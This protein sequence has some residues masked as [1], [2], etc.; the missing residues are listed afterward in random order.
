MY[1]IA[2]FI[3]MNFDLSTD[4]SISNIETDPIKT[5]LIETDPIKA[6]PTEPSL[7]KLTEN[8]IKVFCYNILAD[9]YAYPSRY[10]HLDPVLL[11]WPYRLNLILKKI[12]MSNADII[13]LQETELKTVKKDIADNLP[14]YDYYCHTITKKRTCAIGN[15]TL[16]NKKMCVKKTYF[17]SCGIFVDF[18]AHNSDLEN[19]SEPCGKKFCIGNIHL[20]AGRVTKEA[21]RENQ[22]KSCI[23]KISTEYP[24]II[25]GDFNDRMAPTGILMNTFN[26]NNFTSYSCGLSW[27]GMVEDSEKIIGEDLYSHIIPNSSYPYEIDTFDHIVSNKL[28]IDVVKNPTMV[29]IPSESEPSD[30]LAME[31][32]IGN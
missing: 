11:S 15:I 22:I 9:K 31:F 6:D 30:H 10:P 2:Y 13:C 8:K 21:E 12:K 16:W 24:A 7:I 20:R 3:Q 25:C 29:L 5:D 14:E 32:Y 27:L 17:N 19:T 18:L 1:I 23:K 26:K 28:K 4:N